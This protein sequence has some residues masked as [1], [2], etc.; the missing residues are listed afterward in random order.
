VHHHVDERGGL[1]RALDR[2]EV[3]DESAAAVAAR[4]HSQ[5]AV[6]DGVAQCLRD[7]EADLI[8]ARPR[9][10]RVEVQAV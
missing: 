8:R 6:H 3:I 7:S 5:H 4:G 2:V 9:W 1:R 10:E